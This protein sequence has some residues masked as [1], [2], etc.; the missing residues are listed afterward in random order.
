VYA[1][2]FGKYWVSDDS[3]NA[4]WRESTGIFDQINDVDGNDC[5]VRPL[6]SVDGKIFLNKC[7]DLFVFDSSLNSTKRLLQNLPRS[8]NLPIISSGYLWVFSLDRSR[9]WL[10]K[11]SIETGKAQSFNAKRPMEFYKVLSVIND[12]VA[13]I[14][15]SD[16]ID[17]LD[18]GTPTTEFKNIST[19]IPPDSS[20]GF[21]PVAGSSKTIIY[22]QTCGMGCS[23]P[24]FYLYDYETA[25]FQNIPIL[26]SIKKIFPYESWTASVSYDGNNESGFL[27]FSTPPETGLLFAYDA[28]NGKWITDNIGHVVKI[29]K[30]ECGFTAN[31]SAKSGFTQVKCGDKEPPSLK[32]SSSIGIKN[33]YIGT[34]NWGGLFIIKTE[35]N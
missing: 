28:T 11:Y 8:Q 27:V 31:Y 4:E 20:V 5:S 1:F 25:N 21:I 3:E 34:I 18:L 14:Y 7:E 6:G 26:E 33:G 29:E 13:F 30:N 32:T 16:G 23:E 17:K 9:P 15:T 19:L 10:N 24:E 22:F 2:A 35:S 12:S